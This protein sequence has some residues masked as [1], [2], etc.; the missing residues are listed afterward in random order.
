MPNTQHRMRPRPETTSR[1][2]GRGCQQASHI[3]KT[4]PKQGAPSTLMQKSRKARCHHSTTCQL[5]RNGTT[6]QHNTS[7]C[8]AQLQSSQA[9]VCSDRLARRHKSCVTSTVSPLAPDT[10]P[11]SLLQ[12][13]LCAMLHLSRR[14]FQPLP[15]LDTGNPRHRKPSTQETNQH[16]PWTVLPYLRYAAVMTKNQA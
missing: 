12:K 16:Q 15:S 3:V 1:P 9:Q 11:S 2:L 5:S 10:K 13:S 8:S 14:A 7:L 4:L 6:A